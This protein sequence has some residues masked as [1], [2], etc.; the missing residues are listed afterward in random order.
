MLQEVEDDEGNVT[1]QEVMVANSNSKEL[2]KQPFLL[3]SSISVAEYLQ[4]QQMR[5][6]SFLRLQ[7]AQELPESWWINFVRIMD[8]GGI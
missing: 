4:S 2:L 3:E 7:V 1:S 8:V 5:V 6:D